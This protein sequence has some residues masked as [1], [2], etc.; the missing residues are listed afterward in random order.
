MANI[1]WP[2]DQAFKFAAVQAG[3]E[4]AMSGWRG[5]F[6]GIRE[7]ANAGSDRLTFIATLPPCMSRADAAKREAFIGHIISTDRKSV[8]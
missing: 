5:F 6:T 4:I 1:N 3:A 8:V 7:T 2:T